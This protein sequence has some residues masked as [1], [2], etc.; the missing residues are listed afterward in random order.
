MEMM[1][2]ELNRKKCNGCGMCA[3]I[4]PKLF[5]IEKG[6]PHPVARLLAREV[7]PD[8]VLFS[9][10]AASLCPTNAIT[11]DIKKYEQRMEEKNASNHIF[12]QMHRLQGL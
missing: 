11:L 12:R 8:S 10:D 9:W 6:N 7:P 5:R 2:I 3:V 1:K 4:C